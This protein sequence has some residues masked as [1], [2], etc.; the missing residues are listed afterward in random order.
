MGGDEPL[1]NGVLAQGSVDFSYVG[2]FFALGAHFFDF[3]RI[4]SRLAFF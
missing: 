3:F 1:K 2:S 4:L